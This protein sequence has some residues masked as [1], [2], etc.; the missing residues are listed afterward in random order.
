VCAKKK[1]VR[2]GTLTWLAVQVVSIATIT[3]A[4]LGWTFA[5]NR[6]QPS[7]PPATTAMVPDGLAFAKLTI[8]TAEGPIDDVGACADEA[9]E[10]DL[11]HSNELQSDR[12]NHNERN[13]FLGQFGQGMGFGQGRQNGNGAGFGNGPGLGN[14]GNNSGS[15]PG[16]GQGGIYISPNIRF[17]DETNDRLAEFRL[18]AIRSVP[19][20]LFS[21]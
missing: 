15:G 5:V 16:G 8:P 9:P 21:N 14:G 4:G 3:V 20:K 19:T 11:T 13:Q 2:T 10:V 12:S 18:N 17:A 7:S 1:A 6:A